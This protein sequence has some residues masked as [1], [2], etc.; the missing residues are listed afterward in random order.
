MNINEM[1][2]E[3][4]RIV[5]I[6]L[7]NHKGG[8]NYFNELDDMV[9][10]NADL[11]SSYVNYITMIENTDDII[12]SGEIGKKLLLYQAKGYINPRINIMVTNGGIRKGRE[13]ELLDPFFFIGRRYVFLDDS[14]YSGK[15]ANKVKAAVKE[16]GGEVIK[17]Y[18]FYDGSKEKHDNIESLFRYYDQIEKPSE[19][20]KDCYKAEWDDLYGKLVYGCNMSYCIAED[21]Y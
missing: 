16:N 2:A 20:C 11:V 17:A 6:C 18:V 4:K 12:A 21:K 10:N 9:K 13:V 19:P 8:E 7:R 14:Y 3:M 5:Q 15:T 1:K